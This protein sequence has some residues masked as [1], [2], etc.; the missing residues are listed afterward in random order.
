MGNRYRWMSLIG[1]LLLVGAIVLPVLVWATEVPNLS[2]IG[3]AVNTAGKEIGF[4]QQVTDTNNVYRLIGQAILW[5]NSLAGIVVLLFLI[6]AGWLW[7]TAEGK[8]EKI[9]QAKQIL[10]T[11][12]IALVIIFGAA[13]IAFYLVSA[14]RTGY[15]NMDAGT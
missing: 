15:F 8:E 11:A 12:F 7:M 9:T 13:V 3:D 10:K 14:A 2:N 6:Y 4:T 5:I 1:G